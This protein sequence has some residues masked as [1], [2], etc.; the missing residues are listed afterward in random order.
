[1]LSLA[2]GL[3]PVTVIELTKLFRAQL[4]RPSARHEVTR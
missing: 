3:V 4:A 1:V 2:I